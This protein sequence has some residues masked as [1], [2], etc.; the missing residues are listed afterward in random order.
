MLSSKSQ[1]L[2]VG[3]PVS[4]VRRLQHMLRTRVSEHPAL[5]LPLARRKYPGPEPEVISSETQLVID[6]YTRSASTFAVYAFQLAQKEPV[7]LAH[8]LHAPAQLIAAARMRIPTLVL[9]REPEGAILS[10]LVQGHRVALR[11]ALVAYT[12]FYSCLRP[13]RRSFV[14]GEFNEVTHD[15]GS[16]IRRLNKQF[17][18][19]FAEFVHTEANMRECFQL[20]KERPPLKERPPTSRILLDFES[21]VATLEELRRERQRRFEPLPTR[22]LWVPSAQKEDRRAALHERWLQP[23]LAALR[24]RAQSVYHSFL[25]EPPDGA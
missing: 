23:D 7:R 15:F 19:S 13:Y 10:Q 9:I 6:G 3:S 25:E 18:T 22:D 20:I 4:S 12:R 2:D 17:G 24:A 5:Y 21:G 11:D 8:H 16:V 14:I 1:R